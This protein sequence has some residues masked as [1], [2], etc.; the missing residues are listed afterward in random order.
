MDMQNLEW[1]EKISVLVEF[2]KNVEL[3][4]F[5]IIQAWC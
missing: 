1:K 5:I 3:K 2:V 4:L